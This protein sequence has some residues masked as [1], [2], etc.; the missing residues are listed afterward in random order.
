[1]IPLTVVF[2]SFPVFAAGSDQDEEYGRLIKE[3]TTKPE[4]QSPLTEYMP[5]AD[6][7]PTPKDHLGYIAGAPGKLTYYDDIVGYMNA[8]AKASPLVQVIPIGKSGEGREMVNVLVTSRENMAKLDEYKKQ[9]AKLA[10]PRIVK[11]SEEADSIVSQLKPIYWLTSNLHSPETGSAEASMELAYRL[12]VDDH[13]YIKTI[14]DNM[15][16]LISPSVEPD[17]HD[18]HT[19]WFYLHN[20]DVTE[21]NQ[22][23][24]VPYW[25]KYDLHDNNRDMI[26]MSQSEMKNVAN[27]FFEWYP[28]VIQDNHESVP[29]LFFSSGNGPSS[30]HGTMDAERNIIA[31]WELTQMNAYGM[32]GVHTHDFGNTSWSPN[33]MASIAPNHNA[34]F[35]FY[36]TYGN[37]IGNTIEREITRESQLKKEYYRPVPPYKEVLWSMRNNLNYQI[38]GDIL[39]MYIVADKKDFFLKNFWV[40]GVDSYEKGKNEPPY[41]YVIP[42]GQKDPPTTAFLVNVLLSHKLEIHKTTGLLKVEEGEFPAG[43]YLVRL[44]QPYANLAVT[45]LG[46]QEYPEDGHRT[47]DDCGW[48]LGLNMGVKTVEIKDKSVFDAPVVS[49]TETV[50]VAGDVA[51]GKAS[52]AYVINHGTI[53]SLLTARIKLKDYKALAAEAPFEVGGTTFDAGSIILPVADAAAKIHDDVASVAKELGL[54]FVS[55]ATVPDVK[56]HELDIPRIAI[57]HTWSSTQDDGWVRFAFDELDIPY[58]YI[59][60]DHLRQPGLESRYDVIVLSNCRGGTGADIVNGVD[61][62]KW[63]PLSF[64]KSAEFKHLGT[65]DS[66]Q[67]ITGGMGIAGVA[68][69]QKFV[70]AGGLLVALQNPIRIAVDYGLVRGIR[71]Y[72]PSKTFFN[73]GS[74]LKGEIANEK[75]PIAYGYDKEV[76]MIRRH[77]GP[78]LN[79]PEELEKHVVARYAK[80]GKVCLSGI[81]MGQKE[82]NGKAAIVDMPVG[83]GH[84]VLFT[85][86]PFWRDTSH[87]AYAYVFNA[88]MNYN[89]LDVGLAEPPPTEDTQN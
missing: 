33:F 81:V 20:K 69:L 24:R 21:Y 39:A 38:T 63:G 89:D 75:H 8:L 61:P 76:A 2:L 74:I 54:E 23:T 82:L 45:L 49:V 25:G 60:K 7:I 11:T 3:A 88:I 62:E 15:V 67:D 58:S 55:A 50:Q 18:K 73:P 16:V 87:G 64:V 29:F 68:N 66:A 36:E 31:W 1:L 5:K 56:T 46:I 47:H 43:S 6:G 40:R 41:A 10:D 86:N 83:R 57:F 80:E 28:I 34:T 42:A 79:V 52:G 32:P 51:G 71:Y 14:R 35:H 17:G 78:L 26:T 65:P 72:N 84:V 19:D 53:N 44:D 27:V 77:A 85:F 37:S 13:P 70:V 12:A 59:N 30:F 22:I 9:M 4:F 48:T